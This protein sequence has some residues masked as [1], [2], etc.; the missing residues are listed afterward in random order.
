MNLEFGTIITKCDSTTMIM[1]LRATL[2]SLQVCPDCCRERAQTVSTALVF[3]S[4]PTFKSSQ[5]EV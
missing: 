3:V 5:K 1:S 4:P 2:Q